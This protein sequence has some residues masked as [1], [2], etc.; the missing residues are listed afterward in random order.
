MYRLFA[1]YLARRRSD[2]K[3]DDD[4][5]RGEVSVRG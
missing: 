2:K 1:L 3:M 5:S 4:F